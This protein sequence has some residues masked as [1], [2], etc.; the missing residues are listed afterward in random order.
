MKPIDVWSNPCFTAVCYTYDELDAVLLR[1]AVIP[2][3]VQLQVYALHSKQIMK[4]TTTICVLVVAAMLFPAPGF[5]ADDV[6]EAERSV[7]LKN[8]PQLSDGTITKSPIPGLYQAMLDGQIRYISADGRYL[9]EGDIYD[10][11]NQRNLTE[12]Y[13]EVARQA[14]IDRIG[15]SGMIVFSPEEVKHTVTVF[16]DIDCGYCRKLHREISAYNNL[17][18][19]VR[20]MFFPRSGPDTLSWFKAEKVW[21][22]DDRNLALTQ[23]KG[24][25]NINSENCGPTPVAQH[26]AL[27][28]EI[29]IRGTP[30]IITLGGGLIPGYVPA[31]ELLKQLEQ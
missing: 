22:A 19:E 28:H 16:T 9:I 3:E 17:G 8:Y 1:E 31:K 23:A 12:S 13:R 7:L 30:A 10:T 6:S 20:Y 25:A 11:T 29:G 2:D 26:Y 24:G 27:G 15:D 4:L 21:C 5:T 18:I 14:S